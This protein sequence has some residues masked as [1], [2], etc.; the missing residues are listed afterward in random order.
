MRNDLGALAQKLHLDIT[1]KKK[2]E[3]TDLVTPLAN[4]E[5]HTKRAKEL[6]KQKKYNELQA[7]LDKILKNL[8]DANNVSTDISGDVAVYLGKARDSVIAS[9][10]K[11]WSDIS[12]EA[13][14]A[15]KKS[16]ESNTKQ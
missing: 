2:T 15:N 1:D 13:K 6:L 10:K 14:P 4:A 5:K 3:K 12:E 8:D 11:A 7:E 16:S 9:F